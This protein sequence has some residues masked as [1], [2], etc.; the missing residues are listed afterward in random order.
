[1]SCLVLVFSVESNPRTIVDIPD[2]PVVFE[3][4]RGNTYQ[5]SGQVDDK[6][7]F[8]SI[9]LLDYRLKNTKNYW[10]PDHLEQSHFISAE[11][12]IEINGN[13][14]TL[15]HRPFQMPV[16]ID[17][18]RIFVEGIREWNEGSYPQSYAKS[19]QREVRLSAV[20]AGH[21]WGA[22]DFVFPLKN[23]RL[24]ANSYNNT[25]GALVPYNIY[26]YH[27]GEDYGLIPDLTE[28]ISPFEGWVLASPLP[29]GDGRS[30]AVLIQHNSG[31]IFRA[32]H[33]N[34]QSIDPSI[35]K[36]SRVIAGQLI[37]K[38]GMTWDGRKSQYRDPHF[39]GELRWGNSDDDHTKIAT[40]PIF[41]ESYFRQYPDKIIAIAGG[42]Y[43]TEVGK[44]LELDGTRTLVR[45]GE[46]IASFEWHLSDGHIVKDS[47]AEIK[48]V[49]AGQYAEELIAKTKSG[50][51]SKSYAHVRVYDK[52]YDKDISFGWIYH[53]KPRGVRV[54]ETVRIMNRIKTP[55]EATT[56]DFGD[57]NEVTLSDPEDVFHNYDE[58][59]LYTI[60]VSRIG[61][62]N[63]PVSAKIAIEVFID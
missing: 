19:F 40:Y 53:D 28:I 33:M 16:E 34:T 42:Y 10:F 57:G 41:V 37:G 43:F 4:D 52:D 27:R 5:F 8:K 46:E 2:Y 26:Y 47:K 56:I 6:T 51:T 59:D 48:Y 7:V 1:M 54:G 32:S 9:K 50:T 63:E 49:Q 62:R 29:D 3:L 18:L 14:H 31:I 12:D 36:G 61:M 21:L 39:H 20:L 23:Y 45:E 38:T 44:P 30:N 35:T 13:P 60:T 17:G 22:I 15:Q 58:P 55:V 24:F 11:V 25:W